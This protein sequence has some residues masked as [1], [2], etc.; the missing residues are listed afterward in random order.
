MVLM[1][2]GACGQTRPYDSVAVLIIDRMA[3]VISDLEAC[4]F[5]LNTAVDVSDPENGLIKHFS[6]YEVYMSGPDKMLVNAH[7]PEGHRQYMY[8][9][10]QLAYYSFDEH[11]YGIVRTPETTIRTIDSLHAHYGIEFPAADFF[12]PAFTDDLLEHS[13]VVRFLGLDRID[14]KEY[15]HILASGKEVSYQFWISNDGFNLPSKVV[16][17]YKGKEGNPQYYASFSAWQLNP[18]LPAAMFDFLPPPGAASVRIMSKKD[19]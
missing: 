10:Q 12:Y 16:I 13:D 18:D 17:A 5:K 6:D 15:F 2:L 9:G 4:S 14:G 19:R 8:N 3:D 1:V 7:G 11:N